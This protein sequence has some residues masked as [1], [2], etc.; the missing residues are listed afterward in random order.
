[1]LSLKLSRAMSTSSGL[2]Q[3]KKLVVVGGGQMGSGIAQVSAVTGHHVTIVDVS[4]DVLA[5]SKVSIE[6][7][8]QRVAAK[9]F[10]DEPEKGRSFVLDTMSRIS[11]NT[12]AKAASKDTDLVIEAII[13]NIKIKQVKF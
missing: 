13:E 4:D 1:M 7:S 2:S 10:K 9:Q 6:K 5:K 12:D 8:L 3:I 11:M